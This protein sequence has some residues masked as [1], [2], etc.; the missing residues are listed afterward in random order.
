[1]YS[2][3]I[4]AIQDLEKRRLGPPRA[5][6]HLKVSSSGNLHFWLVFRLDVIRL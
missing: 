3:A 6:A 2:L 4:S 5:E 1:M